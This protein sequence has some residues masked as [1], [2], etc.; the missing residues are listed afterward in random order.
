L[1]KHTKYLTR[2]FRLDDDRHNSH[3]LLVFNAAFRN[4]SVLDRLSPT[5]LER[6]HYLKSK[7]DQAV[8]FLPTLENTEITLLNTEQQQHGYDFAYSQKIKSVLQSDNILENYQLLDCLLR[9]CIIDSG[10]SISCGTKGSYRRLF[11]LSSDY[12]TW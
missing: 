9:Y 2:E 11:A 12:L 10:T 5:V 3:L 6:Y 1:G 8:P 7:Y 4:A